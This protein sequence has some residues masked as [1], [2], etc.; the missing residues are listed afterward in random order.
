VA[1]GDIMSH[2]PQLPGYY[3][4]ATKRYDFTPWF[5]LVKPILKQGDWVVGNLET[6]LAGADL[7][8]SGYPRFNAPN[9]LADALKDAGF[10]ILTTANNHTLDRGYAGLSRTLALLRKKGLVPVGTSVSKYDSQRLTIVE[11]NGIRLGFLAY[12]YGT[13]G[14]PIPK[15]HPYAVNLIDL[16]KIT[17]DIR[18]LRTAGADAVVVS[19]H[20]GTEYQLMPNDSQ[21]T[22][23]RSVIAAGADIVLGSHPH[24]VQPYET[25]EVPDPSAPDGVRRGF[26]IYSMGN[27]VSN[28]HGNWKD[29]GV[30][31][32]LKLTKTTAPDGSSRTVWSDVRTS[33]TW[34][35]IGQQGKNNTY[36]IYPLAQTLAARDDPDLTAADYKRMA[37]YL[38]GVTERLQSLAP[39]QAA[40]G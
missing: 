16:P 33:P 25:V 28:Q 11:K 26:V 37:G 7:I 22:I 39:P 38:Q 2:A 32:S 19:L 6:P 20:F 27:F 23:A 36:T 14:I 3:D 29:V 40:A 34:V 10:G 15:S 13:N 9:E 12:T 21:K 35:R 4:A 1:V 18:R 17:D 30:I 8:Y 31:V 24:V 5:R